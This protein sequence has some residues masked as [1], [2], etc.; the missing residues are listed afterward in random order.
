MN[1]ET[2]LRIAWVRVGVLGGRWS[3]R[4]YRTPAGRWAY[5]VA[6]VELPPDG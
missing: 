4:G 5:A 6:L 1:W 2:A 3:V